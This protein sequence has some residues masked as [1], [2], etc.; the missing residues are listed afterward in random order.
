MLAWAN[1]YLPAYYIK[2]CRVEDSF[3]AT[4]CHSDSYT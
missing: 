3:F 4:L 1:I 2:F